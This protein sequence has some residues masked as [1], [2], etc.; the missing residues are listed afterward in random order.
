MQQ[1]LKKKTETQSTHTSHN[2]KLKW[3][4][5]ECLPAWHLCQSAFSACVEL[6][7]GVYVRMSVHAITEAHSLLLQPR[8]PICFRVV[9]VACISLRLRTVSPAL[10]RRAVMGADGMRC[11]WKAG[12]VVVCI[13][14]SRERFVVLNVADRT[15]LEPSPGTRTSLQVTSKSGQCCQNDVTQTAY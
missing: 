12:K 6:Y 8:K 4:W 9:T 3:T 14:D 2:T 10:M 13:R 11:G 5:E 1:K 7:D 15:G